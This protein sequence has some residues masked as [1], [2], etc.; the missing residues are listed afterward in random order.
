M[1]VR[2]RLRDT[3]VSLLTLLLTG[4]TLLCCALPLLLITLGLGGTVAF[5]TDSLPW[6]V[7]LSHFKVWMFIVSGAYLVFTGWVIYRPGR[8]CP[9]DPELARLCARAD[10]FNR[11]ILWIAVVIFLSGF[12]VAYL[13]FPLRQLV[14]S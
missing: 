11:S 14:G 5:L 1:I 12:F 10:R 2:E 9:A 6:L 7:S 4:G 3:A 13:L 8:V